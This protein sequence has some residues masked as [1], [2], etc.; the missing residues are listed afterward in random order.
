MRKINVE[1]Y[2]KKVNIVHNN[3]YCYDLVDN[4]K[5]KSNINIICKKHGVFTQRN[6]HHLNG[7][8]CPKCRNEQRSISQEEFIIRANKTHNNF[9][10][11]SK[12]VFKA[13]KQNIIIICPIHGEFEQSPEVHIYNTGGCKECF[14]DRIKLSFEDFKD[15]VNKK[16]NN[17]F[18]YSKSYFKSMDDDIIIICPIH[19]E[20]IKSPN[21][22][23]VSH[24][25]KQCLEEYRLNKLQ[26]DFIE[27]SKILHHNKYDYSKVVYKSAKTN[28]EIICPIHGSFFQ[29]PTKHLCKHKCPYCKE[30]KGETEITYL[31]KINNI[32]HIKQ[33]GFDNC[34]DINKL[35]F[36]FYLPDFNTCIEFDGEQHFKI[37]EMWGGEKDF[38]TRQKRDNIKNEYC[39]NNN[40]NLIRIR[41]DE[42]IEEKIKFLYG[43]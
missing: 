26:I 16:Y 25:C 2:I 5:A 11:Y 20:F 30:S 34:R 32:K 15:R 6:D 3:L 37:I 41:Y 24:G 19:G 33:F 9:Y 31:L 42:N 8:I 29:Q 4:I 17:F 14:K 21:N 39:K 12:T 10:N 36:D 7:S 43:K 27:K 35:S 18:D 1:E 22:H 38:I 28:V 40:I 13:M 23:L